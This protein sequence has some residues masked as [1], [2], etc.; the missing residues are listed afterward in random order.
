MGELKDRQQWETEGELQ[1]HS[2]LVLTAQVLAL[3]WNQV[4]VRIFK[5]S[6]LEGLYVGDSL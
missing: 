1:L 6:Q 5:S 3:C 2:H 4:D